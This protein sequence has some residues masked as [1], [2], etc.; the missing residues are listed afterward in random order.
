MIIVAAGALALSGCEKAAEGQVAAVVNGEE[1]T[2]QEINATLAQANTPEGVD[3]KVLQQ[4]ALQQIVDRRLLAQ[5]ARES[6]IDQDPAY[7][8]RERQLSEALLVQMYAQ[9]A[10]TTLKVPDQAAIDNYTEKHPFAF[11]NRTVY[12]VDQLVFPAP[13]N[14]EDLKALESAQTLDQVGATLTEMGIP[15]QSKSA[16]MDSAQVPPAMMAQIVS[17]APGEPFVIPTGTTVTASVIKAQ[18]KVPF[19]AD[20]SGP[21]AVKAIRNEEMAEIM[22]KRL[23]D[24]KA[25]AEITYQAGFEPPKDS[26]DAPSPAVTEAIDDAP[27]ETVDAPTG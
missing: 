13:E 11:A 8:I 22:K 3:K 23:G 14:L 7:L 2:L 12:A 1:I 5:A 21:V 4:R 16:Q 6:G 10:G 27:A 19:N 20:Q 24:A 17:L 9:K 25:K 18:Q 26:G 15:F